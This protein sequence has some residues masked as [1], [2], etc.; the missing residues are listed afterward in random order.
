MDKLLAIIF[1]LVLF[2]W[3]TSEDEIEYR[4]STV[5]VLTSESD[6]AYLNNLTRGNSDCIDIKGTVK[7]KNDIQ[8]FEFDDYL[9]EE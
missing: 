9:V 2:N 7:C 6:I 1:L 8:D 3:L 4:E 5:T